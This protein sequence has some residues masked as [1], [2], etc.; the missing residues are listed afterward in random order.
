MNLLHD[1]ARWPIQVRRSF[2]HALHFRRFSSE[3]L[4][5]RTKCTVNSPLR[6]IPDNPKG[7]EH[8]TFGR[9]P[10]QVLPCPLLFCASLLSVCISSALRLSSEEKTSQRLP[11][12][13]LVPEL[14]RRRTTL[15]V[16]ATPVPQKPGRCV[17]FSVTRG[18]SLYVC[19]CTSYIIYS[20]FVPRSHPL[21]P[22]SLLRMSIAI[23][24][25]N[26]L[27]PLSSAR[28]PMCMK[29]ACVT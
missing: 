6:T 18:D 17:L 16:P 2:R 3:S 21:P 23:P 9:C 25:Q 15:S 8:A 29:L 20:M 1:I 24:R 12:I 10:F 22:L 27:S 4:A 26:T 7:V 14:N 11:D 5:D 13:Q 19:K 28:S